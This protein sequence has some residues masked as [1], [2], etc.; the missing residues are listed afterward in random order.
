MAIGSALEFPGMRTK[1][2]F[3]NYVEGLAEDD[4]WG[5]YLTLHAAANKYMCRVN[6]VC[7]LFNVD[8]VVVKEI[9]PTNG[10]VEKEIYLSYISFS[11][12]MAHY[13]ALIH[14]DDVGSMDSPEDSANN[15]N[16]LATFC[17]GVR[18]MKEPGKMDD[19]VTAL[20]GNEKI[21]YED[22]RDCIGKEP[23]VQVVEINHYDIM[24]D[25]RKCF[26]QD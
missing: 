6:L 13:D 18:V 14:R 15:D 20:D 11:A 7:S 21:R 9:A 24:G 17:D 1:S 26:V 2:A 5:S 3:K 22:G 12:N 19:A 25:K 23:K 10:L 16:K 4:K 8:M